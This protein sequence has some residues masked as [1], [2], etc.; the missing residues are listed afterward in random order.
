MIQVSLSKSK[1]SNMGHTSTLSIAGVSK[2]PVADTRRISA[3]VQ[4][5]PNLLVM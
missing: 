2:N 5:K 1:Q 3:S 4:E